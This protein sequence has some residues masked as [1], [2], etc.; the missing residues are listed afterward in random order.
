MERPVAHRAV[1]TIT[2]EANPS[3]TTNPRS[4]P[5]VALSVRTK[6]L[7]GPGMS[8]RAVA[9]SA[10]FAIEENSIWKFRV[11]TSPACG[12]SRNKT[13]R[14]TAS[15]AFRAT[16]AGQKNYGGWRP[17]RQTSGWKHQQTAMPEKRI[18]GEETIRR[19]TAGE[20]AWVW[21][22]EWKRL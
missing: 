13:S 20:T 14:A 4:R 11:S 10:K 16:K 21:A 17:I 12:S 6:I 1:W 8:A 18:N 22:S 7:S 9:A 19:H 15:P 5:R 2:P 3:D